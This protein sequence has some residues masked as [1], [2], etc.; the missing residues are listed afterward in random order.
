MEL[1]QTTDFIAVFIVLISLSSL[2][3]LAIRTI[4]TDKHFQTGITL[5]QQKDFLGAEAAF[6]RVIAINSTNDVV[7]LLL[8]DALMQQGKVEAAITEFQD[9]IER[10]PKKV[11]AYLRLAQALMQQK[12]P[13]QAVTVLEQA[14]ALFQNQRQVD[15]AEKVQQ[16]L[17]K[18]DL[19]ENNA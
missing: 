11:D 12:K 19:S 16:L 2:I 15:K 13:Q 3:Y 18:I 8:G 17:D 6:R 5:Y 1:A 10:A 9:V 4:I 14:E 7:H